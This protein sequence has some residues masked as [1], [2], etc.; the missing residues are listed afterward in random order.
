MCGHF[1]NG[2]AGHDRP[3]WLLLVKY[4]GAGDGVAVDLFHFIPF[5][6]PIAPL[7]LVARTGHSEGDSAIISEAM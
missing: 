1:S 4:D 2:I 3:A 5:F 6:N 7:P